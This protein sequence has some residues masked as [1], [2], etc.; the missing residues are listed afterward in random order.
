MTVVLRW[1]LMVVLVLI[2]WLLIHLIL[3][4]FRDELSNLIFVHH[5][6]LSVHRH[7]IELLLWGGARAAVGRSFIRRRTCSIA[8]HHFDQ[9]PLR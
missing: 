6:P 5:L 3:M 4:D 7:E 1:W 2:V 8:F 9:N